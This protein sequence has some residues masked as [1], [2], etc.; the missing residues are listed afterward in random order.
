MYTAATARRYSE[1]IQSSSV[2]KM[3]TDKWTREWQC[4]VALRR[5]CTDRF[6]MRYEKGG[7]KSL[8]WDYDGTGTECEKGNSEA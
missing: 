4:T 3:V 8:H 7:C 5:N 6:C 2:D 1:W